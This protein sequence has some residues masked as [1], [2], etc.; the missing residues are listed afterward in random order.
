MEF[1][2]NYNVYRLVRL[3]KSKEQELSLQ[4]HHFVFHVE[5]TSFQRRIHVMCL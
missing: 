5:T 2:T 3:N 4:T 1:K